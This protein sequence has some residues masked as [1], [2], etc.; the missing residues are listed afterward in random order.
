MEAGYDYL[1]FR[2]R[3]QRR[4]FNSSG[5]FIIVLG[6]LLLMSSG[7]YYAYAAAARGNLQD[8]NAPGQAGPQAGLILTA[9]DKQSGP[10][11]SIFNARSVDL[12]DDERLDVQAGGST[13]IASQRSMTIPASAISG[14]KLYPNRWDDYARGVCL[15]R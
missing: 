14:Q 4:F 10:A 12:L 8:L 9:P 7:G 1:L 5:I 13:G 11:E 2:R 6:A 3:L 15:V